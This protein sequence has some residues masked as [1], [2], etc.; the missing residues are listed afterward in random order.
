MNLFIYAILTCRDPGKVN[1]TGHIPTEHGCTHSDCKNN[2][3]AADGRN[4]LGRGNTL[5]KYSINQVVH[6]RAENTGNGINPFTKNK[7]DIAKDYVTDM[8]DL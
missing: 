4:D 2:Y 8:K 1:G 7:G 5:H 3:Y 6:R